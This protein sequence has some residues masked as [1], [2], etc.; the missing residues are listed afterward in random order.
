MVTE[1]LLDT[2]ILKV[3][4]HI[5]RHAAELPSPISGEDLYHAAHVPPGDVLYRE[6]GG[7][8]EDEL[9]HRN[10]LAMSLTKDQHFYT[11]APDKHAHEFKVSVLYNGL[12]KK[13]EV[14]RDELVKALLDKAIKEFNATNPHTLSLYNEGGVELDDGQTLKQAGV[15]PHETLLLRP[16]KVKGG[17]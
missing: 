16:S 3:R 2:D 4:V 9:V 6:V 14:R 1:M 15:K 5:D 10:A 12:D 17:Q 11:G 13:F 7:D 8:H